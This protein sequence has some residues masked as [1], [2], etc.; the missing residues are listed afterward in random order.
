VYEWS[1]NPFTNPNPAY[2]YT[3]IH[4]NTVTIDPVLGKNVETKNEYSR[5]YAIGE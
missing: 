3:P 5:C 2:G 1:I 4:E